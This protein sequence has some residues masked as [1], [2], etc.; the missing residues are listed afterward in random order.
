MWALANPSLGHLI[1]LQT[2]QSMYDSTPLNIFRPENLCQYV[3]HLDNA[4]DA[5]AWAAC[6][7]KTGTLDGQRGRISAGFDTAPD[8]KHAT[9]CV[10]ARLP[11]GRV[12]VEVAGFWDS[13]SEAR[14]ALVPLLD[15]IQ[16]VAIAWYPPSELAPILRA[17]PGSTELTGGKVA[18]AAMG[19]AGAVAA[20]ELVHG[21]QSLLDAHVAAAERVTSGD[22]GS[23]KFTRKGGTGH[24]DGA[25]AAAAAV[26][27]ALTAPP[28]DR[29]R[30]RILDW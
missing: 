17:R 23:W 7:D 5:A 30:I 3:E 9:L 1:S 13:T 20:R 19:L 25:Y 26:Q 14:G 6:E 29:P 10:A 21:G 2:L 12:R 27:L 4:I 18:E 22:G 24:V 15:R 11:D 16:P 28:G 8:D